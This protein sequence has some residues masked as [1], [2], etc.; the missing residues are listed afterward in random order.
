MCSLVARNIWEN[1]KVVRATDTFARWAREAAAQ[2]GCTFINLNEITSAHYDELGRDKVQPLFTP[3][4]HTHTSEAG[5]AL[6]ARLVVEAIRRLEN[7]PLA[8][9]LRED[10]PVVSVK[11]AGNNSSQ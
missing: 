10:A 6:N 1:D 4:D 3:A 7:C 9:N 11:P 5:A 2:G 8:T